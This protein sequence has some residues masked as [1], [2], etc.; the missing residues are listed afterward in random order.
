M[1]GAKAIDET[2]YAQAAGLNADASH[3]PL[4]CGTCHEVN[5]SGIYVLGNNPIEYNGTPIDNDLDAAVSWMHTYTDEA[6]PRDYICTRCHE[7]NRAF[8]A[9]DN[10][11]WTTHARSGRASR[12][13]MDKAE[14]AQLG[15]VAGD[16]DFEAP[17]T[18][19][20]TSCHGN[21][22]RTLE[23]KGCTDR[24]KNHLVEGRASEAVWEYVT[25]T[26]LDTEPAADGTLCGW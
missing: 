15:H 1:Y 18:T 6:D 21:R 19:V 11:K 4:K 25:E 3:G 8:I 12:D 14:T 7:D 17:E 20:C 2:S 13:A 24:W 16:P 23:R 22:V 26:H 10:G 9:S 5:A